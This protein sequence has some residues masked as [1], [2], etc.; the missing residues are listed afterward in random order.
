ML[1]LL[2]MA[3]WHRAFVSSPGAGVTSHSSR[4]VQMAERP[5]GPGVPPEEIEMEVEGL[6]GATASLGFFL[7][8]GILIFGCLQAEV[9][10]GVIGNPT[11]AY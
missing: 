2:A 4:T 8:V 3:A 9:N 1:A 11:A 5:G 10:Q 7:V 6:D